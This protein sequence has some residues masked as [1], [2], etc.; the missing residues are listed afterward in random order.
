MEGYADSFSAEA[1]GLMKQI[2]S[3]EQAAQVEIVDL[4][5]RGR[6]ETGT[7]EGDCSF[8]RDERQQASY[9]DRRESWIGFHCGLSIKN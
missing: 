4:E 3:F 1:S 6:Q 7:G 5:G 2:N 9:A 8:C